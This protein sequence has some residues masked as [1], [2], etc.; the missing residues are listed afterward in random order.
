MSI[1]QKLSRSIHEFTKRSWVLRHL[2]VF[3]ADD[4]IWLMIGVVYGMTLLNQRSPILLALVIGM[5]LFLPWLVTA[6]ISRFVQRERPYAK[7]GYQ[8]TIKPFIETRSFPSSHATFVFCLAL[9]SQVLVGEFFAWF[10][11][12][13]VIVAFGR[14]AVGVHYVS[15]VLVGMLIGLVGGAAFPLMLSLITLTKFDHLFI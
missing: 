1:D 9:M 6:L 12:G 15:D 5:G 14:V 10:L 8:P 2:A 7:Q 11:V 13:A 4:L 3:C